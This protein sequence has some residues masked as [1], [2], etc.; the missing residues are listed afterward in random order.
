[1]QK[2]EGGSGYNG[3]NDC[4]RFEVEKPSEQHEKQSKSKAKLILNEAKPA[5]DNNM[6]IVTEASVVPKR[7]ARPYKQAEFDIIFGE[8]VSS[9]GY[10][11]DLFRN[12][13]YCF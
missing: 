7:K 9:L 11:L 8:G 6:M 2:E 13:G 10:I 4:Q 12:V 5:I 3:P 1:M